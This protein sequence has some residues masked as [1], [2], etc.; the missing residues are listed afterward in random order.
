MKNSV[1]NVNATIKV[2]K[3]NA[4]ISAGMHMDQETWY[5]QH[6]FM[7]SLLQKQWTYNDES[8]RSNGG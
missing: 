4:N 8:W 6:V 5:S 3:V 7:H 2:K 1:E